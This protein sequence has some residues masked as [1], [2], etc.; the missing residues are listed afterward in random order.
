[1]SY[2]YCHNYSHSL[3]ICRHNCL[4]CQWIHR[5]ARLPCPLHRSS[6]TS[7][8]WRPSRFLLMLMINLLLMNVDWCHYDVKDNLEIVDHIHESLRKLFNAQNMFLKLL[9]SSAK[10][11]WLYFW[12]SAALVV[13][14]INQ[15]FCFYQ[16]CPDDDN[17]GHCSISKQLLK[18]VTDTVVTTTTTTTVEEKYKVTMSKLYFLFI[19]ETHWLLSLKPH[20]PRSWHQSQCKKHSCQI[21]KTKEV[22]S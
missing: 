10:F 12:T 9:A 3:I 8:S 11:L 1:M 5:P 20:L 4:H 16:R 13:G 7:P 15:S 2:N 18:V 21:L 19:N 6:A 14:Y 17:S 22:N